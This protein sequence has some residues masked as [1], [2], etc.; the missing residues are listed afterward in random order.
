MKKRLDINAVNSGKFLVGDG[1]NNIKSKLNNTLL[2]K[3]LNY[4]LR[5]IV[6]TSET[7]Y[8]ISEPLEIIQIEE[9]TYSVINSLY[10]ALIIGLCFILL[11]L[12]LCVGI[13]KCR[14][15]NKTSIIHDK[16]AVYMN[17]NDTI[18]NDTINMK[19]IPTNTV[20]TVNNPL[21]WSQQNKV[22]Y[23]V[24][25]NNHYFDVSMNQETPPPL[26]E[27]ENAQ[28]RT[29]Y[30][31]NNNDDNNDDYDINNPYFDVSNP[32]ALPIKEKE[33]EKE[34]ER[35]NTTNDID[36]DDYVNYYLDV[37]TNSSTPPLPDKE[38]DKYKY[39]F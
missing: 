20:E 21:Y 32:P 16:D 28:N 24:I 5:F 25:N 9:S 19:N 1:L 12:L 7:L 30:Y 13:K 10:I 15:S 37:S 39:N 6:F 3:N 36:M 8:S 17:E 26:Y 38:K 35:N 11:F 18:K 29:R 2:N 31:N 33:K 22:N 34:K 14:T 4:R 23:D 27:K